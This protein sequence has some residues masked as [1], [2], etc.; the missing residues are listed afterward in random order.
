M[1]AVESLQ[2]AQIMPPSN[3]EV[4][5]FSEAVSTKY[6]VLKDILG[7]CDGLKIQIEAST[8][9]LKQNINCNGWHHGHY[10]NSVFVFGIDGRIRIALTNSPGCWHDS[11]IA[12]YE[13]NSSI[14]EFIIGLL[15]GWL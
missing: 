2:V 14:E 11:T 12:E 15:I 4:K 8:N 1:A 13:V 5:I 9:Y 6:P 3:E 10:I 7:A